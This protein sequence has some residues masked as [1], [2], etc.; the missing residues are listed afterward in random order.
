M[1]RRHI[2]LLLM[3]LALVIGSPVSS[4]LADE[5]NHPA[6]IGSRAPPKRS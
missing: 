2:G 3:L 4:I 6:F 1:I 5:R